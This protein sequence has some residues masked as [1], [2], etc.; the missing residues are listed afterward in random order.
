MERM[1]TYSEA[2]SILEV[3]LSPS[4]RCLS[5]TVAINNGANPDP[6]ANFD[7]ARLVP[8]SVVQKYNPDPGPGPDP[9]PDPEPDQYTITFF[10]DAPWVLR[11][12]YFYP[13]E[14]IIPPSTSRRRWVSLSTGEQLIVGVTT[15]TKSDSYWGHLI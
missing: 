1:M 8:A 5:K 14:L 2:N 9:G 13:G 11:T 12:L 6:L 10:G 15:A 7:N 3:S 4:S